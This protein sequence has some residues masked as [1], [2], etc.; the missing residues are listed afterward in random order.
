MNLLNF[1][2]I[3]VAGLTCII[4]L[5][6]FAQ[7]PQKAN[8]KVHIQSHKALLADQVNIKKE[9]NLLDS[10]ALKYKLEEEEDEFPSFGLYDDIWSNE[11]VNPYKRQA[12]EIPD[13][14]KIDVSEYA[15]PVTNLGHITSNFGPRRRRYHYGTDL[16]VQTGDTIYAAF[17]GKIRLTRY[18]R[19][20][21]GYHVVI[22][23][24][25]GLETVYGHLSKFLVEPD[26]LVKVGD[27]IALGGNTGR[28]TGSHLH[29]ETR[30]L[31]VAINPTEIFDF[32]NQVTH[33]DTYMFKAK[34]QNRTLA[35]SA[36]GSAG[37]QTTA[38]GTGYHRIK[39]GDTLGMLS[40][41]YHVSIANLCKMN[42]I[43]ST[44]ILRLGQKIRYQ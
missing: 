35:S 19:K 3:V 25:N 32:N 27:P 17:S 7:S 20:G 11:W 23:H 44:T 22:R 28:S 33:T 13:S 39:Q 37:K 21:Y 8:N 15:M 5:C 29:F 30:F 6:G 10:V 41:K 14:F 1:K 43:K 34:K 40:R 9:I 16:K 12:I 42:N 31:G 18:E 38:T 26:Q 2:T 24:S 36:T 4:P